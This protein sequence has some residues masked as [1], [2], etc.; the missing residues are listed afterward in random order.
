[1]PLPLLRGGKSPPGARGRQRSSRTD[2]SGLPRDE[3]KKITRGAQPISSRDRKC[4]FCPLVGLSK[5]KVVTATVVVDWCGWRG[6]SLASAGLSVS[7][8]P[9]QYWNKP[10]D[11]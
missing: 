7:I 4:D 6:S 11:T 3:Q 8:R 1:M 9:T 2:D 10:L 5:Q